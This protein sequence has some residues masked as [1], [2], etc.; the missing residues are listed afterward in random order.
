MSN[1]TAFSTVNPK[2]EMHQNMQN[3]FLNKKHIASIFGVESSCY[4]LHVGFSLVAFFDPEDGSD[5]FLRNN[6]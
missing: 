5:M 3:L 4:L 2:K 6:S 1:L